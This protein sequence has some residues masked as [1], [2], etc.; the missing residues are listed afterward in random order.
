MNII[1]P[2][3][4]TPDMLVSSNVPEDEH[5]AWSGAATYGDEDRVIR[6]HGIWESV[7]AGNTGHDPLLDLAS[8]WW[9]R[10]SATNRWRAFDG[11]LVDPVTNPDSISYTLT[12]GRTT[13]AI[14]LFSIDAASVQVIVTDPIDGV[15]YDQTFGL[16]DT[17]PIHDA[18]SYFFG[19]I[20]YSPDLVVRS[21]PIWSGAEVEI[22]VSGGAVTSVGE[23]IIG[24]DHRIGETLVDT[25]IGLE[26]YSIKERGDFG[27]P[28]I[29]ELGFTRIVDYRFSFQT[30]DARRIQSIMSR[31][32]ARPAVFSSGAGTERFGT[33]IPGFYKDFHVPLTTNLSFGTLEVESL[34]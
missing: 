21:I 32:R 28:I 20:D 29:V 11:G 15:I 25:S 4:I 7:Q 26:D 5:P 2:V 6:D 13:D 3:T 19:P 23:I 8:E 16:I 12:L 33:S 18:W 14:A 24:V 17:V 34:L 1:E 10:I 31:I 27:N 22:I 30:S 9:V